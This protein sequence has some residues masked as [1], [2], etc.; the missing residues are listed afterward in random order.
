MWSLGVDY[1]TGGWKFALLEDGDTRELIALNTVEEALGYIVTQWRERHGIA[2][3]LPSGFGVPTM[4]LQAVTTGDLFAMSLLKGDPSRAGLGLFLVRLQEA[5]VDGYCLPSVKLLPAVPRWR[6]LN[7]V[8]MG[9]SDKLCAAA[10][11]LALLHERRRIPYAGLSFLSLEVGY[12]FKCWLVV[13]GGRIVDGIGGTEGSSS[14]LARGAI[15][16]ELAYIHGFADKD[17]IYSGGR[18]DLASLYGEDNATRAYWEGLEKERLALSSFYG[19]SEIVVTGRR[20]DEI[21]D[22]WRD[23]RGS[24]ISV[25]HEDT[26]GFEP[27]LGAAMLANGLSGGA[28]A[29]LVDH[30]QLREAR[31]HP[32]DGIAWGKATRPRVGAD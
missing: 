19:L 10:Y 26:E 21:V 30:V 1:G 9:T 16:G 24:T 8:D 2:I 29:S 11:L 25:L 13:M 31:G 6:T 17:D 12:A 3:S 5:G 22:H 7:K 23:L 4:R 32:L 20:R 27:A 14:P 15:D 28:W 18:R